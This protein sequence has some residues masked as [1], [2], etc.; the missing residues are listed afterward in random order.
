MR[1]AGSWRC[2]PT[3]AATLANLRHAVRMTTDPATF[4]RQEGGP[5]QREVT[6]GGI[7]ARRGAHT[8]LWRH[9]GWTVEAAPG[10]EPMDLEI[11]APGA[12]LRRR[13]LP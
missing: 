8:W 6:L 4:A 5:R 12:A 2:A 3:S 11:V 10:Y 9:G 7:G 1:T 13:Q